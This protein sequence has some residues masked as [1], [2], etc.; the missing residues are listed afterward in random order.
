MNS[1]TRTALRN[2]SKLISEQGDEGAW[3]LTLARAQDPAQAFAPVTLELHVVLDWTVAS[4]TSDSAAMGFID[5][6]GA[7]LVCKVLAE[8]TLVA[9]PEQVGIAS[10]NEETVVGALEQIRERCLSILINLCRFQTSSS[11]LLS[12]PHPLVPLAVF[13]L[14]NEAD[15]SLLLTSLRLIQ[16][17]VSVHSS[18]SLATLLPL[19]SALL[20]NTSL[21]HLLFIATHTLNARLFAATLGAFSQLVW[22]THK[23][24]ALG[25]VDTG[26]AEFPV[27]DRAGVRALVAYIVQVM[28]GSN[29]KITLEWE[30]GVLACVECLLTLSQVGP[31]WQAIVCAH[32]HDLYHLFA[33]VWPSLAVNKEDNLA[34]KWI[35]LAAQLPPGGW[36][37]VVGALVRARKADKRVQGAIDLWCEVAVMYQLPVGMVAAVC[38]E[39]SSES[40]RRLVGEVPEALD[41]VGERGGAEGQE[42]V[43]ELV[44]RSK[45]V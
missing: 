1:T 25:D 41:A 24:M 26:D 38:C 8:A 32:A 28:T 13:S 42:V 15:P 23:R 34:S 2:L 3:T 12:P 17:L 4:C 43:E 7:D 27:V 6:G 35:R 19:L 40:A 39:V 45:H 44:R 30:V 5:A 18:T 20:D 11:T 21:A 16:T 36:P 14:H 31:A 37:Q 10:G 9:P 29:Q 33:V 22:I